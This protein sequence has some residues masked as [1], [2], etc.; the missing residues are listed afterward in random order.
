[1]E[2]CAALAE[3]NNCTSAHAGAMQIP[4]DEIIE[5]KIPEVAAAPEDAVSI[6]EY[7][8][9]TVPTITV[10]ERVKQLINRPTPR[11]TPTMITLQVPTNQTRTAN[12][13][14]AKSA[15]WLKQIK[16]VEKAFGT[17][18]FVD[19]YQA[20]RT[21][22]AHTPSGPTNRWT[23]QQG[24]T[25]TPATSTSRASTKRGSS[26]LTLMRVCSLPDLNG[27]QPKAVGAVVNDAQLI[28][29][30]RILKKTPAPI[31]AAPNNAAANNATA[32]IKI[33]SWASA[34]QITNQTGDD[35]FHFSTATDTSSQKLKRARTSA[36]SDTKPEAGEPMPYG[37]AISQRGRSC[38]NH[39]G[40][41]DVK[42]KASMTEDAC[43][44]YQS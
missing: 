41:N 10:A 8:P 37:D 24:S 6:A 2:A 16:R 9:L 17:E 38:G 11:K 7:E 43:V 30:P 35:I 25:V 26:A 20:S 18:Y 13:R 4:P 3:E 19:P 22:T 12:W 36:I 39:F 23:V 21:N 29:F 40:S 34:E 42:R 44:E 31:K 15:N 27:L 28:Q 14:Q 33:D 32:P 5:V 1:M